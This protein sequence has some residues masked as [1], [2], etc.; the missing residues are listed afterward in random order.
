MKVL[1]VVL[2]LCCCG[3]LAGEQRPTCWEEVLGKPLTSVPW[4]G[5]WDLV[6]TSSCHSTGITATGGVPFATCLE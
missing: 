3:V 6:S 5:G 2:L 4:D 1:L